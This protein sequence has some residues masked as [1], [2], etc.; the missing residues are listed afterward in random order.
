MVISSRPGNGL[1]SANLEAEAGVA[2]YSSP[3]RLLI[4]WPVGSF[5]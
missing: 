2:D 4:T 1:S 5:G 3:S